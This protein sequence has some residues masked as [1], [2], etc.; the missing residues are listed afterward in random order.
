MMGGEMPRFLPDYERLVEQVMAR[1]T[2]PD[3]FFHG[4]DHWRRVAWTGLELLREV[5]GADP[6]VVFLFGLFHDSMRLN[7]ADDPDHGRRAAQFVGEL[8]GDL[9][10]LSPERLD[11]LRR[12]CERHADGQVTDDPTLGVCWDADRLNLWRVRVRPDPRWLSTPAAARRERRIEWARDLQDWELNWSTVHQG[13]SRWC[14]KQRSPA[15]SR[16]WP[17]IGRRG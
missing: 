17:L 15:T 4:P 10:R 3:S 12:A 11:L 1:C 16:I 13:F 6:E 7:D 2:N 9:F 14:E 8:H 5:R